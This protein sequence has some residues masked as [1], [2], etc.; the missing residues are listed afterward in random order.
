M[1]KDIKNVGLKNYE[2]FE[3]YGS[4]YLALV[5]SYEAEDGEHELY[6]PK[7]YLGVHKDRLPTIDVEHSIFNNNPAVFANFGVHRFDLVKSGLIVPDKFGDTHLVEA[8]YANCL[9]KE[10][11]VEMT[12]E[13]IE[14]KL[15]HKI[16]IVSDKEE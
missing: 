11:K 3:E 16:K 15:G 10:K 12:L 7:V 6:L 9:V 14:K 13:E 8:P 2:L 4:L 1:T 5:Y